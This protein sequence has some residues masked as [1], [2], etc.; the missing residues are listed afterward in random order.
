MIA[1]RSSLRINW[2]RDGLN[3]N[4]LAGSRSKALS[5]ARKHLKAG[6]YFQ[7]LFCDQPNDQLRVFFYL[8]DLFWFCAVRLDHLDF[9]NDTPICGCWVSSRLRQR[10]CDQTADC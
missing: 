9:E 8:I 6:D 2:Q 5:D 4:E 10:G 3:G 1:G 7:L